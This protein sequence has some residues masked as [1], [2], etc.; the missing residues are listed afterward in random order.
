[1]G[2][3]GSAFW[4]GKKVLVSGATGFKGA[5]LCMW[6][7]EMGAEV[8]GFSLPPTAEPNLFSLLQP[9]QIRHAH[10]DLADGGRVAAFVKEAAPAFVFHLAA[11]SLVRPSYRDPLLTYQTNVMGT[12]NML[13][14][15]RDLSTLQAAVIITTDK[16]YENDGSGRAFQEGDRLG[17]KDPYSNSKACAEL[18]TQS[19][20]QSFFGADAP[21]ATARAGNVVGG[22]DWSE[23][24]L[25][26]DLVRAMLQGE[27]L[28]LRYPEATRPWQ[29][30]LEPL[31]GYLMLAEKLAESPSDI[32]KSFNFGPDHN[33]TLSVARV[34]EILNQALGLDEGWVRQ[35]GD[36]PQEAPALALDSTRA[37]SELGWVPKM[38]MLDTIQ[39]T[40][41]WYRRW[42]AGENPR[43]ITLDQIKRY[44][45]L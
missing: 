39:W 36:H 8:S 19:F 15:L 17:G 29:H 10:I 5:W 18:L 11:Q 21:I 32:S 37:A 4:R 1:M 16:V 25:V 20:R 45:V 38:K 40:A 14:A 6:L 26:P 43:D 3:Q 35:E 33:S 28:S 9:L 2:Y 13:A 12:G 34:V 44:E 31:S 27:R 22:G 24:R 30:V 42:N 41:E 23:D 7:A